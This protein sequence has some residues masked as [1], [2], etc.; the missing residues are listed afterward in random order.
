M[1]SAASTSNEAYYS[2]GENFQ[3][4]NDLLL[5]N[6]IWLPVISSSFSGADK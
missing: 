4:D 2:V 1:T 3:F 6:G 5:K